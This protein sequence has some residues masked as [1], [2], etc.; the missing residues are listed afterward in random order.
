MNMI[1]NATIIRGN[2]E[3]EAY[4][5]GVVNKEMKRLNAM[6]AAEMATVRQHRNRLL[7]DRMKALQPAK[8][9]RMRDRLK[10]RIAT[11]WAKLFGLLLHLDIIG[12]VEEEK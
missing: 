2:G 7:S 4:M 9:V 5:N 8:K 6:H 12:V 1:A 11:A 10:D 3:C